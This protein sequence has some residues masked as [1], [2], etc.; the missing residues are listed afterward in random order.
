M[1]GYHQD[2]GIIMVSYNPLWHNIAQ[3]EIEFLHGILGEDVLIEHFGSTAIIGC[4]AKDIVDIQIWAANN[5]TVNRIKQILLPIYQR[6]SSPEKQAI[7]FLC[8]DKEVEIDDQIRRT[9]HIHIQSNWEKWQSGIYFRDY[10]ND[11]PN[12]VVKYEQVKLAAI[13]QFPQ[14]MTAYSKMKDN[15]IASVI[16]KAKKFYKGVF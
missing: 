15:Y 13:Q 16:H 4:Q 1:Q 5:E 11:H 2:E 12:E 14:D 6:V 9:H 7:G 10:L 3:Q 8:F